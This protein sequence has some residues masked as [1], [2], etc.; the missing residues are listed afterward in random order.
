MT[1]PHSA[2]RKH[3][4]LVK[5]EE[6]SKSN[7]IK[8]NSLELLH[9]ILV[10]TYT[11]LILAGDTDNDWQDIYPRV[12]TDHFCTSCQISTINKNPIS[13][14]PLNPRHTSSGYS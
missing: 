4:F 2:Q 9:H 11:S 6:K 14:T 8:T 12:D 1:F 3:D 7:I 5:I 10:H 13:K